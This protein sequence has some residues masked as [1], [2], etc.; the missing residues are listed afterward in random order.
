MP[1]KSANIS[2]LALLENEEL[3]KQEYEEI[4]EVEIDEDEDTIQAP[5]IKI[6]KVRP[7]KTQKQLEAFEITRQKGI[8]SSKMRKQA[9]EDLAKVKK[10]QKEERIVKTAITI[11]KKQ[12][13]REAILDEVSDDDEPKQKVIIKKVYIKEPVPPIPLYTYV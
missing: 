11:K 1:K 9:T 12:I 5:K 13:K 4:E 7:P 3:P 10:I 6:K 8:A 2:T